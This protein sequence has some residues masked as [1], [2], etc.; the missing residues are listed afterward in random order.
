M[1]KHKYGKRGGKLV[2]LAGCKVGRLY[3]DGINDEEVSFTIGGR[4]EGYIG[5]VTFR[6]SEV[7]WDVAKQARC[8]IMAAI[9]LADQE[10]AADEEL[11]KEEMKKV[12]A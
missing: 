2:S 8:A 7:T 9:Q 4:L 1:K 5:H 11:G 10:L 6:K 3:S 12:I